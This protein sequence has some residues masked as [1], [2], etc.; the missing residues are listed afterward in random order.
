MPER[1]YMDWMPLP[2]PLRILPYLPFLWGFGALLCVA[3]AY[4]VF[5]KTDR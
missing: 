2:G 5:Y 3:I 4:F 1:P